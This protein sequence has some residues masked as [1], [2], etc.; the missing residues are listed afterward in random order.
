M[1]SE[2]TDD[3]RVG[4]MAFFYSYINPRGERMDRASTCEQKV[5][6]FGSVGKPRVTLARLEKAPWKTKG[7]MI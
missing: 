4:E 3:T 1:N 2:D 7:Q 5:L 6:D